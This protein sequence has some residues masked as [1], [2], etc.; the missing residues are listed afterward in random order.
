MTWST[1]GIGLEECLETNDTL[2]A[3]LAVWI[4]SMKAP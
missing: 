4:V 1:P 3:L 2:K